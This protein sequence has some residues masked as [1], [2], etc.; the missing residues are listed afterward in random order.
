MGAEALVL[1]L[2]GQFYVLAEKMARA[3]EGVMVGC[4]RGTG[5][6]GFADNYLTG[7]GAGLPFLI[8]KRLSWRH[9]LGQI[10]VSPNAD[11]AQHKTE[12]TAEHSRACGGDF[13]L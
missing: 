2:H 3:R 8:A 10:P 4:A 7:S 13:Q 12:H 5:Q 9:H 6:L 1:S 11:Q